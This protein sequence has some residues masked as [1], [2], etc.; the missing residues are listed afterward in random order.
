MYLDTTLMFAEFCPTK[1]IYA[2]R[3]GR[4]ADGIDVTVKLED[5]CRLF[6]AG[7]THKLVCIFLEDAIITVGIGQA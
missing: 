4:G 3:D 5:I 7:L 6:V 2:Y 1:D